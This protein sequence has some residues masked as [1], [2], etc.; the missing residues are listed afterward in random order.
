[1]SATS[2]TEEVSAIPI[3][4]DITTEKVQTLEQAV[5]LE[6]LAAL[7]AKADQKNEGKMASKI[8]SSKTRSLNFGIIGSGQAGGRLAESWFKKGY[9]SIALNTAPQDLKFVNLPDSNKLLLEHGIGGASKELE[10]GR[11]AA[12]SHKQEIF[13]LINEK[14]SDV[15]AFILT[16]SLGGGSGSGSAETLVEILATFGKPIMVISI[17]PM[18][19]EDGQSKQNSLI[20]LSTL[21]GY[22]KSKVINNL[23]VVDNAKI[24]SIYHD[25]SQLAFFDTANESIISPLDA[26]NTLSSMPSNSKPLDP[27]EFAKICFDGEGLSVYGE[28][29]ISNYEEDTAIAESI[30]NNLSNNLLASGFDLKQARY[31]GFIVAA[32]KNVW[33]KIPS[34]SINYASTMIS[35][36]ASGA[37]SIFK[38]IYVVESATDEVKIYSMFSG[39]GLPSQRVD[40][41]KKE[42]EVSLSKVKEKDDNRKLTLQLDSGKSETLNSA[43]KIKDKIAAKNSVFGK[44][45][46][47]SISDRRK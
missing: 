13:N 8:V 11:A 26:F 33:D 25:V 7:R 35:D 10:I 17:L 19:N 37:R 42:V 38:G 2:K 29:N 12:E 34:S 3:V 30:V 27:M 45:V 43:Q 40:E 47:G 22:V 4:D 14:L 36:L 32:N 31:V 21:S 20:T 24:E 28:M 15:Q 44:F 16:F 1:M 39:L 9:P 46:S 18:T 5:N 41:L 6:K 23:I